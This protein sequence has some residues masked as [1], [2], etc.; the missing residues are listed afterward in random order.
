MAPFAPFLAETIYQ[1][2]RS[3]GKAESPES[4]HL[5]T[6]PEADSYRIK[7]LLERAV[8]RMQHIILLGRQKRNQEKVKTKIPL[9][10]L[11]VIHK[12]TELLEE[13]GR[14][15]DYIKSELNVKTVEYSTEE[16]Q[17]I[18]LYA[19][20]N[21]PVL[22]K[23]FG[24]RFRDVKRNIEAL[25]AST[26]NSFQE[27]GEI[28]IEGET[29]STDDILIFREAREGSNA[30]SD[31]FVSIDLD[32]ELNDELIREG[33]AREVIS[34]IQKSRKDAGL[35]VV[36]R[37]RLSVYASP[38]LLPAISEFE[39]HIMKETLALTLEHSETELPLAFEIDEHRLSIAIEKAG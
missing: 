1:E 33:L 26:I 12:D 14:L 30:L 11:T 23:R 10:R 19:K 17:Y 20:P 29:L 7:P 9:S 28:E 4:V 37:I 32:C 24:K 21:S 13:I 3:F 15:D 8:T 36:D 27:A 16:D 22:G 2:L 25:D 34:R 31:R 6:Y 39:A 35:N 18:T 38:E 5:C